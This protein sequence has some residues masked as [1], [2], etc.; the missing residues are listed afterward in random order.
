LQL[1][2]YEKTL[3]AGEQGDIARRAIQE[4]IAVGEFFGAQSFV[5]VSNSHIM[6][7]MESL[8]DV[9]YRLF[10]EVVNSGRGFAVP[11]TTNSRCVDPAA[12]EKLRQDPGLVAKESELIELFAKGGAYN[13]HTC[14]PYQTVYQPHFGEHVAW[15]DTGAVTYANSVLGARTNYES[16]PAALWAA[17]TGR[18]PRY[19]F[20]LNEG[21]VGTI[22]VPVTAPMSDF[23]DWGALGAAIGRRITDYWTVPVIEFKNDVQPTSDDLKHLSASIA[24]HGSMA[25]FHIVGITPE[26]QKL[27]DAFD[28]RK[29]ARTIPIGPPEIKEIY[30]R[31][32]PKPGP[33]ELVVFTAPQLSL[34][35]LRKLVE[36]LAGRGVNSKTKMIVTTNLANAKS[37]EDLGYLQKLEAA[38]ALIIRETCWYIM[39]PE[40]MREAFGWKRVVSNSAKLV[41]NIGGARYESALLPTADCIEAAVS[42]EFR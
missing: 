34:F 17:V 6:A 38:G 28:G 40:R 20:H 39:S 33:V 36:L 37:A 22:H 23:S 27:P 1:T 24:S 2:S 30:Q 26:A 16:G 32:A 19:G 21:R 15:G 9:G 18:T 29:P 14:I 31:Y 42:G 5:P 35:E 4:Q 41:N 25:M 11:L 13:V 12:A 3:L 8:G 10:E 7:T